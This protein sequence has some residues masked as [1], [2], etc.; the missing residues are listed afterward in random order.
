MYHWAKSKN[1]ATQHILKILNAKYKKADLPS[2][3]SLH[4]CSLGQYNTLNLTV[5][6]HIKCMG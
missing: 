2:V 6:W 1:K 4:I 5:W 3:V